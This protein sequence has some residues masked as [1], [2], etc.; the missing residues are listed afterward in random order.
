MNYT[1][2]DLFSGCG[3]LS[4]GAKWAGINIKVAVESDSSSAKTYKKN[5]PE[6]KVII[7]DIAIIHP[8]EILK[9]DLNGK[10]PFILIAGPP[11]Q[12]FSTSN[13]QTRNMHN[14]NNN[15]Y[16]YFIDFVKIL[17]PAWI[18]F[19]NVKG[20]KTFSEGK[21]LKRIKTSLEKEKY[22]ICNDILNSAEYGIPQFRNR[23]FLIGWRNKKK[24]FS[25]PEKTTEDPKDYIT[26]K[27]ALNDL[28]ALKNGNS[29]NRFPYKN[30]IKLS[31]YQKLLRNEDQYSFNHSVSKNKNYVLQRYRH[32]PVGG[33]WRDI[34]KQMMKNYRNLS[35]CHSGIYHRLDPDKPSVVIGNYRKNM[36][37][38]P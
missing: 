4:L 33:N 23:L 15:M 16:K 2:I 36:L 38:H 7:N 5:H 10:H 1:A 22:L 20:L 30:D 26:I 21:I 13:C 31:E 37:I 9:N 14:K 34:P 35:N 6:T 18:L 19:E 25:F 11:C 8:Q 17:K 29:L 12:G 28:P 27:N 24:S 3:G 32:I